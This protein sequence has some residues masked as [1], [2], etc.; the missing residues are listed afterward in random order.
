MSE[1]N[2]AV[3]TEGLTKQKYLKKLS[4]NFELYKLFNLYFILQ[5]QKR[6]RCKKN[7]IIKKNSVE[8]RK[9]Y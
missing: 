8:F 4:L 7:G 6:I 5:E 3:F 9:C 2:L 1:E